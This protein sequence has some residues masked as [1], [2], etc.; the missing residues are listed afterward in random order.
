[1]FVLLLKTLTPRFPPSTSDWLTCARPAS[2]WISTDKRSPS[3]TRNRRSCSRCWSGT[4][5]AQR[6]RWDAVKARGTSGVP[7]WCVTRSNP[8]TFQH[9][10]QWDIQQREGEIVELQNALSDM[11]VFLFQERE[12]ALRLYAENDRLKLRCVCRWWRDLKMGYVEMYTFIC[13]VVQGV[14]G[15]EENPAPPWCGR[16]WCR[17]DHIFPPGTSTQGFCCLQEY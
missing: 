7:V 11:Q 17:R 4:G 12:Q 6:T 2:C 5:G 10:L 14:G 8:N 15:Q 1:M 16:S 13:T 9:K 3:L